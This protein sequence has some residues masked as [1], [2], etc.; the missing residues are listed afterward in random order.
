[1]KIRNAFIGGRVDVFKTICNNGYLYDVNSLYPFVMLKN[2]P[3]G[4]GIY[5]NDKNL[6]NYFGIVFANIIAPF[7]IKY[8]PLPFKSDKKLLFNPVGS[9]S[10]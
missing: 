8:P 2:I 9:F 4:K 3:K 6:D 10:G 7:N 1:M 5:T